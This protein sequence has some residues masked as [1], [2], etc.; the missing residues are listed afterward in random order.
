M[1]NLFFTLL[2]TFALAG[3]SQIYQPF[4]ASSRQVLTDSCYGH[5]GSTISASNAINGKSF[6]TGPLSN[7]SMNHGVIF[8]Y[9]YLNGNDTLTFS[10][11]ASNASGNYFLTV[12]TLNEQDSI[13]DTLFNFSYSQSTLTYSETIAVSDSGVRKIR[14]AFNGT[15]GTGR[16]I[17]DDIYISG[18]W[19]VDFSTCTVSPQFTPLPVTLISFEGSATSNGITLMWQTAQEINN[20]GFELYRA[21]SDLQFEMIAWIEG[22]GNSN[23]L[24]TYKYVDQFPLENTYYYYLRQVDFDGASETFPVIVVSSEGKVNKSIEIFPNPSNGEIFIRQ[25]EFPEA[26]TATIKDLSGRIVKEVHLMSTQLQRQDLSDL[27][28]GWYVLN[29]M[30]S[31][32]LLLRQVKLNIQ[33]GK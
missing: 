1:K 25:N 19:A 3:F 6:R 33:T 8:P 10:H 21:G 17:I 28:D 5:P 12:Y 15:G 26:I 29:L 2:F 9:I 31:D 13:I 7:L 16:G 22:N 30:G 23:Q 11:K 4:E 32:S 24:N 20:H 18:E 14:F 27:K